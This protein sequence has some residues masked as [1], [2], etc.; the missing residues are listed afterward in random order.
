MCNTCDLTLYGC[1]VIYVC[2]FSGSCAGCLHSLGLLISL[3]RVDSGVVGEVEV[4]ARAGGEHGLDAADGLDDGAEL[5]CADAREHQQ[6]REDHVVHQRRDADDTV[7][8]ASQESASRQEP[9]TFF[10]GSTTG[11]AFS[12]RRKD[13]GKGHIRE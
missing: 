4:G 1:Q 9:T 12:P 7:A 2:W 11:G 6:R 13:I 10:V 3:V 8:T 5:E